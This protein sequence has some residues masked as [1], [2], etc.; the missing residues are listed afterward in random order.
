MN[1]NKNTESRGLNL[2]RKP[3]SLSVGRILDAFFEQN[4]CLRTLTVSF[5]KMEMPRDWRSTRKKRYILL[6]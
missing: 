3:L 2:E 4:L 5:G 6:S 1:L